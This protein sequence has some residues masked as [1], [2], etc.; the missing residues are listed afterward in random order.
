MDTFRRYQ[1]QYLASSKSLEFIPFQFSQAR[2]YSGALADFLGG[3]PA[4][5]QIQDPTRPVGLS[6]HLFWCHHNVQ[7]ASSIF[8]DLET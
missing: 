8:T 1:F 3:L 7:G 4:V 5:L 6:S 2:G